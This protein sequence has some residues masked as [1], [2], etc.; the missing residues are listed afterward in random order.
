MT[1]QNAASAQYE[2]TSVPSI[3]PPE[4]GPGHEMPSTGLDV[5]WVLLAGVLLIAVGN[6]IR[7]HVRRA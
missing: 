7:P 1:G 6:L 4:P 3:G 2:P 5:A